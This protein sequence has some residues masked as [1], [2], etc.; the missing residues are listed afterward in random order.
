MK[1][2]YTILLITFFANQLAGAGQY[3]IEQ[4]CELTAGYNDL[5]I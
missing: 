1:K 2:I 4:Y 5:A 3:W